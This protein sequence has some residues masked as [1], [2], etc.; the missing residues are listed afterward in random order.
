[1]T[2]RARIWLLAALLTANLAAQ[3]AAAAASGVRLTLPVGGVVFG[4]SFD[5]LLELPAAL[6][7]DAALL[8]PLVVEPFAAEEV[9]VAQQAVRRHRCHARCYALGDVVIAG[10]PGA[11]LRVASSL[12]SPPGELEWPAPWSL[13]QAAP[14]WP[15]LLAL[16]ALLGGGWA[17]QRRGR[18]RALPEQALVASVAAQP[19]D[20]VGALRRLS[21]P[22]EGERGEAF[23][24]A[25]KAVLR[26]HCEQRFAVPAAVR[27]SEELRRAVPDPAAQLGPCLE[28]CDA[29]LF[30]AQ[31]PTAAAHRAARDAALAFVAPGG[32][33]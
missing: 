11:V 5:L 17:F 3:Q 12:P 15:W 18:Q 29:V 20:L 25:I 31:R 2:K 1:M 9:V 13:P 30:A 14:L 24:M 32:T 27:T 16:A 22:G 6:S 21:L 10:V 23:Y 4:A 28:A 33:P 26:R 8:R 7:F 19:A